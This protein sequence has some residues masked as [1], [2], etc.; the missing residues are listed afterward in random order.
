MR[1]ARFVAPAVVGAAL[2][3]PV[4][5]ADDVAGFYKGRQV[6]LVI[7]YSAGGGYDQYA[8]LFARHAGNH[9]PG[10]PVIVPKNMPGA[11]SR[12]AGN[13]IY[14]AAPR[15]GSALATLGQNTALDQ[16]LGAKNVEFDVRKFNWLGNIAAVN[17]VLTV[18]HTA[19]VRTVADARQKQIVIG[20]TGATSPSVVYPQVS[21]NVLGTKFRIIAGYPG[22][23]DIHLAMERGEVN[24]RGS[25]SWSS[26]KA[27]RPDWI[28]DKK[29][30]FLFQVGVRRHPELPDVP[31]WSEIPSGEDD[32]KVLAALSSSI[33]IGYSIIAPPEVPANR[34]A[35]LRQAFDKTVADRAFLADAAKQ[36]L[37][38]SPVSGA[39]VATVAAATANLSPA[40]VARIKSVMQAK[41]VSK[42]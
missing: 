19:G 40:I 39:E 8:R 33:G 32:R 18:W 13:W 22:S 30:V 24:G 31:L 1:I 21:N 5:A 9:I 16:A 4:A 35:A 3:S 2:V 29:I 25:S 15:D 28:R 34:V 10:N 42:R 36:K 6:S 20:A 17:N 12:K 27:S 38:V 11:G 23:N 41:D 37:D 7:G 14:S 26:W